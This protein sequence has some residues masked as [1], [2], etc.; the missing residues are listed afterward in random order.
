M[1]PDGHLCKFSKL[2]EFILVN[3]HGIISPM[4]MVL[5]NSIFEHVILATPGN[6][7]L[8]CV[9]GTKMMAVGRSPSQLW[10]GP[11][12]QHLVLPFQETR[13]IDSPVARETYTHRYR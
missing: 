4:P 1:T 6:Y 10:M 13:V 8:N 5:A 12:R 3:A 11:S 2:V 9:Y 7:M